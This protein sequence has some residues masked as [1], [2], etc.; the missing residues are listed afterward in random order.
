M[1]SRLRDIC[2]VARPGDKWLCKGCRDH[3]L[4]AL[5]SFNKHCNT[6]PAALHLQKK[7]GYAAP[8][9]RSRPAQPAA[10]RSAGRAA[11]SSALPDSPACALHSAS[12]GAM[13][14]ASDG[15]QDGDV[16]SEDDYECALSWPW[17]C[18]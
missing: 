10:S 5:S 6:C 9:P 1:S 4:R 14:S 8:R 11:Q 12:D 7:T 18:A 13:Y 17:P 2:G 3:K 15:G 16:S